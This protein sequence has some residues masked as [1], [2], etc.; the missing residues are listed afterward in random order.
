MSS[1][2]FIQKYINKDFE[3]EKVIT[4]YIKSSK[5]LSKDLKEIVTELHKQIQSFPKCSS[6]GKKE[7]IN[8]LVEQYDLYKNNTTK[9]N[10]QN[11]SGLKKF[12][13]KRKG[14][15][16]VINSTQQEAEMLQTSINNDE[17]L[18]N[19][20]RQLENQR[21]ELLQTVENLTLEN[22]K[23]KE[24][25]NCSNNY[26]CDNNQQ[27]NLNTETCIENN[28]DETQD[29]EDDDLDEYITPEGHKYI[30]N[31][32]QIQKLK[33]RL[34]TQNRLVNISRN[35]SE[36]NELDNE[37]EDEEDETSSLSRTLSEIQEQKSIDSR[38]NS[39]LSLN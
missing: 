11:R 34:E 32:D 1:T 26:I 27:C 33:E 38:I 37:S 24:E 35:I 19:K 25:I 13:I 28:E 29:I 3:N 30:G 23:L 5:L 17:Q 9:E 15:E 36:P 7:I 39:I 18:E 16:V 22:K 20:I 14:H 31:K 12:V 8:I 2:E 4:D 21:D 6:R 10:N